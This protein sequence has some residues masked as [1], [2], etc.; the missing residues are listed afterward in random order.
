R[1]VGPGGVGK[2]VIAAEEIIDVAADKPLA[3]IGRG[4]A[5][6]GQPLLVE[7]ALITIGERHRAVEIVGGIAAVAQDAAVEP[8]SDRDVAV[9]KPAAVPEPA[10]GFLVFAFQGDTPAA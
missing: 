2:E 10:V 7:L 1:R 6:D 3:V 8:A 4:R 5:I 9:L